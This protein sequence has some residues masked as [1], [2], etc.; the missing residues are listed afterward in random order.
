LTYAL[1]PRIHGCGPG[2]CP[3]RPG[4]RHSRDAVP[5]PGTPRYFGW[6]EFYPALAVTY[7]DTVAAGD[8]LTAAVTY[9]G[10]GVY[11]LDLTDTTRGW[12]ENNDRATSS[13]D[14][15]SS[16]EIIAEA[17]GVPTLPLAFGDLDTGYPM[18]SRA[19]PTI[20][21]NVAGPARR[22]FGQRGSRPSSICGNSPLWMTPRLF[23]ARVSA[24]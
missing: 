15:D 9:L 12:T 8:A 11:D 6:Y 7:S 24:T 14:A 17:P 2:R 19:S 1:T 13:G 3:N 23:V 20:V 21:G 4:R 18:N 22:P 16:V 10:N 5:A